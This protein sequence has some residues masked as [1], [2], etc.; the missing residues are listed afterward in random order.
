MASSS[1]GSGVGRGRVCNERTVVK[2]FFRAVGH[3][4]VRKVV[5]MIRK[6]GRG[7]VDVRDGVKDW[8]PIHFACVCGKR[9]MAKVLIKA[10]S[11]INAAAGP[12][13]NT[14]L[15]LALLNRHWKLAR[16][17]AK[18]GADWEV[19]NSSGKTPRLLLLE[20]QEF[21]SGARGGTGV[22]GGDG[23]GSDVASFDSRTESSSSDG[24]GDGEVVD[25]VGFGS[26]ADF[27]RRTASG[28]A[29]DDDMS[30]TEG[31]GRLRRLS[32][33][34]R[35][36]I[37]PR[38]QSSKAT[39][40]APEVIVARS[41]SSAGYVAP[42]PIVTP[43]DDPP[44]SL[45]RLREELKDKVSV[46]AEHAT[47]R[48][49]DV[50]QDTIVVRLKAPDDSTK[51]L[52]VNSSWTGEELEN[53][54]CARANL[55]RAEAELME[56]VVLDSG[57]EQSIVTYV[58]APE[59]IQAQGITHGTLLYLRVK[60][61]KIPVKPSVPLL[62]VLKEQLLS[63]MMDGSMILSERLAIKLAGLQLVISNGPFRPNTFYKG[64]LSDVSIL[65]YYL[66]PY[67]IERYPPKLWEDRLLAAYSAVGDIELSKALQVYVETS[68]QSPNYGATMFK[69]RAK[70]NGMYAQLGV[71]QD[72]VYIDVRGAAP[73]FYGFYRSSGKTQHLPNLVG[74][75][76]AVGG[77]GRVVLHLREGVAGASVQQ[78]EFDI[79]G[80]ACVAVEFL[81][82]L[83]GYY[84]LL[85]YSDALYDHPILVLDESMW[86]LP[87]EPL[88]LRIACQPA[89]T[90]APNIPYSDLDW[91]V[92]HYHAQCVNQ[93]SPPLVSI[94]HR[95]HSAMDEGRPWTSL[96]VT[97]ARSSTSQL[98]V[99]NFAIKSLGALERDAFMVPG[100][101]RLTRVSFADSR[102]G[103]RKDRLGAAVEIMATLGLTFAIATVDVSR[104]ELQSAEQYSRLAAGLSFIVPLNKLVLDGNE[105]CGKEAVSE[106]KS[107][108]HAGK[109]EL[110]HVSFV[111]C[112]MD[113]EA[114]I[115]FGGRLYDEEST[116]TYLDISHNRITDF[117]F[118]H[119]LM[120]NIRHGT[121]LA[122]LNIGYNDMSSS[123]TAMLVEKLHEGITMYV[124]GLGEFNLKSKHMAGIVERLGAVGV[125]DISHNSVGKGFRELA[126]EL[127][128]NA[129]LRVLQA[130][131]ASIESGGVE[132]LSM[133]LAVNRHLRELALGSNAL[134]S[135][136]ALKLMEG[137][138]RS[139]MLTELDLSNNSLGKKFGAG[140]AA[141]L[142]TGSCVLEKL[143]LKNNSLGASG[144][145]GVASAIVSLPQLTS[146]DV[147]DT[148]AE[149]AGLLA[150]GR[151][152]VGN[153]HVAS[154]SVAGNYV[155]EEA[156]WEFV[157][158][159]QD[160]VG[161]RVINATRNALFEPKAFETQ[162]AKFKVLV[163][164]DVSFTD[165]TA[166]AVTHRLASWG[167]RLKFM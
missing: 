57:D 63:N 72:G 52:M 64:F 157:L 58:F 91:F 163:D 39:G 118:E 112:K 49:T 160:N 24:N 119:G 164:I 104:C 141:A 32:L 73:K 99:L 55:S 21:G 7:M 103:A 101:M 46:F 35:S 129:T 76:G 48:K 82:L 71:A 94:F 124:L 108:L 74:W 16:S 27:Y 75:Q 8:L 3:G 148:S 159:M 15:H 25:G 5:G 151:A 162:L 10:G 166:S 38:R 152:L 106:L 142:G 9:D 102:I 125:L 13:G 23:S 135:K 17:L 165:G 122:S 88:P 18:R 90:R 79:T 111:D 149:D 127:A 153:T 126:E 109:Q 93:S 86:L 47:V 54:C 92:E 44:I 113:D 66:P 143:V 61:F 147:S 81:D 60:Y 50:D 105:L 19:L 51:K 130:E 100:Q 45:R 117:G 12:T 136:M 22:G 80:G 97:D 36:S 144:I 137:V 145:Q 132:L 56:L 161:L 68:Q 116:I 30:S 121:S 156:L 41:S 67:L 120:V 26:L 107:G 140:L 1:S 65:R 89:A 167:H 155:S 146:L 96:D 131:H 115:G 128:T 53:F 70:T 2:S 14:P 4:N 37:G 133:S 69:G 98:R 78:V 138:A 59:P 150:L 43:N 31:E 123:S 154:L 110:Q 29:S 84:I 139:R 11:K 85:V 20:A 158:L 114:I 42:F 40:G 34:R 28:M 134:S 6:H 77:G 95:L 83:S 87:R 33:A 62:T